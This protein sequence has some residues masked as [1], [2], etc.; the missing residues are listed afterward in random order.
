MEILVI[1]HR[2]VWPLSDLEMPEERTSSW[3]VSRPDSSLFSL[4]LLADDGNLD[5]NNTDG[6]SKQ[7]A[8]DRKPSQPLRTAVGAHDLLPNLGHTG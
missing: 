3:S 2:R 1:A 4:L 6:Y 8:S 5:E 7:T